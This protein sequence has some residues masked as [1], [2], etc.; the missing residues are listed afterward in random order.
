[1]SR[2]LR[3]VGASAGAAVLLLASMPV[4]QPVWAREAPSRVWILPFKQ[5][6][7][8]ASLEHLAEALPALLAV[9]ITASGDDNA[10]VERRQLDEVLDEQS[11]SLASLTSPETRQRVGRLL[12]ATI[13]I[14]GSYVGQGSQ[15]L[16]T[17][18]AS[19]LETGIIRASAEGAG[20]IGQLGGLAASLYRRLAV[21]LDRRLPG[22]VNA[23]IDGA[24]VANLHFMRG[25]GHYHSARYSHALAEFVLAAEDERLMGLSRF[26]LAK[27]YLAQ[28][29][30]AHAYL[31]LSRLE[32]VDSSYV[33]ARDV[34]ERMRACE[35]RLSP[36]DIRVIREL[37]RKGSA[38]RKE[39]VR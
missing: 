33:R 18:R 25:L 16:V 2:R 5:L 4:R 37:G 10:V 12:G 39:Q 15:I 20:S 7:A 36:D 11:L 32:G 21:D 26:W 24:P 23:P 1:M 8:D 3:R 31:E 9:A 38:E 22:L 17:M 30:Y 19:D 27:T 6:R 14:G 13:L 35:R 28:G 34:D 29:A